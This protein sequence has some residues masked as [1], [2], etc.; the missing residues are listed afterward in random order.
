MKQ[1]KTSSCIRVF[2]NEK[3]IAAC[4]KRIESLEDP[5]HYVANVLNLAGNETRLKILFLLKEE[6]KL[7]PCDI[8][9]ILTMTVPAVSQHLRKLKDG[10]LVT[11]KKTGQ[12]VFY[13]LT[14]EAGKLLQ[15]HFNYF[16][17][18]TKESVS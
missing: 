16:I 4:K 2:A 18:T 9:D 10:G 13:S 3:Q 1:D 14:S 11:A 17:K 8:S 7:C 15:P 6:E 5:I 12:T